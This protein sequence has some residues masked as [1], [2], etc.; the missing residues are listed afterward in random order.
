MMQLRAVLD[1]GFVTLL[2]EIN[3]DA[4]TIMCLNGFSLPKKARNQQNISE[5]KK[6]Y[7]VFR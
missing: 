2:V 6:K 7:Y 3:A 4:Q 1:G 5:F